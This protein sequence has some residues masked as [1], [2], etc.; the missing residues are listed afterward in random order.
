MSAL[1][2]GKPEVYLILG[3]NGWIGGQLQEIL[4]QQG[5]TF[6][7]ADSRTQNRE[8]L[9]TELDKYQP[10]HVLNA[11][12]VTGRPNVDWCEDH[13]PETIRSNVIG[14][15]NVADLCAEKGIHHLL[16]AT[17]CIFE[18]DETHVIGGKGFLEE[19]KPNFH[20]SFYSHTK[21]MVE[22]MLKEF[23]TTCTLRVRM[24]ISD[25]LSHRNFITKIVKYDRVVNIPNSMTCLT[26]MLPISL[27]MAQRKLTGVY[28]FC[29]PG[30][31]SHNEI[32]DLYKKYIDPEYT[33]TNFTVEE[34]A[35][36]LK[37]GRS[38]NTLDHTKL[39]GALSDITINEIHVAMEGVF[40]RMRVNLEK[41]GIWPDNLPKRAPKV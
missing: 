41:Q 15:L 3:K 4:R 1:A 27:I 26:E 18:Y 23:P 24:P 25:D 28:N 19:D 7:L 20:G 16:Y 14:V 35:Q 38:N 36:I 9:A 40:Q 13:R 39:C 33:Y 31:I 17:G 32:L 8:S 22:D 34:Q 6:F 11:A 5:K 10:T 37:A 2:D 29:N 21:A 12:G 30:A